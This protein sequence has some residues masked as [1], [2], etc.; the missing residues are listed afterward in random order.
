MKGRMWQMKLNAA[1][2]VALAVVLKVVA[3]YG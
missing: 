2:E 3:V 1:G